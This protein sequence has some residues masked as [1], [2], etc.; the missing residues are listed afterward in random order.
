MHWVGGGFI[1]IIIY[2]TAGAAL[3][4]PFAILTETGIPLLAEDGST[5]QVEH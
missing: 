1:P 2:G 3:L 5:L 4:D